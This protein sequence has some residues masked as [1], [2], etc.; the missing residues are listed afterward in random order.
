MG[1]KSSAVSDKTKNVL[2]EA[3]YFTPQAIRKTARLIGL[4]SDSSQR[5]E[6]GIDPS[7]TIE[8]LNY[9]AYLLQKV[10]GGK[11]AKGFIDQ[12]AHEFTE[13]KIALPHRAD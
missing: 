10:A 9:A 1:G 3:A 7:A 4:K 12:K 5:F 8:A 2:I 11:V 13:K 6:K